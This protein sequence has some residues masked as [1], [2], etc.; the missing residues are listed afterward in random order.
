MAVVLSPLP[1]IW[2]VLRPAAGDDEHRIDP[3]VVAFEQ[4]INGQA[5]E[6]RDAYR[7]LIPNRHRLNLK[8]VYWFS[9]KDIQGDC[10]FC[11]SVGLFREGETFKPKPS[12]RAF[13]AISRGRLRP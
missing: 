4:G 8:Q 9:W 2:Q 3:N 10:N 12:W 6:L 5:R 7:Y 11:D 1:D 13:V